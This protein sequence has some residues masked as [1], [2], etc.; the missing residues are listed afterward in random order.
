M[1]SKN[2]ITG[3]PV[4][5]GSNVTLTKGY[6]ASDVGVCFKINHKN[7]MEI[8]AEKAVIFFAFSFSENKSPSAFLQT[9]RQIEL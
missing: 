7:P 8:T 1:L 2:S 9:K 6:K 3:R 4:V 5:S